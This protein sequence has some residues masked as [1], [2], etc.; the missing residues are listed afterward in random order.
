MKKKIVFGLICVGFVSAFLFARTSRT[1]L[2][3]DPN[4]KP[5]LGKVFKTKKDLVVVDFNGGKKTVVLGIPGI[6]GIPEL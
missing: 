1:N 4:Y 6:S 3:N 2:D 5:M